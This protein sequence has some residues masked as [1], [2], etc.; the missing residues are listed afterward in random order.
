MTPTPLWSS[1]TLSYIYIA[2]TTRS[3]FVDYI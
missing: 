1:S 3:V 2:I